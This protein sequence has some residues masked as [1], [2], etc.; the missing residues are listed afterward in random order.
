[1]TSIIRY[2][3]LAT[4]GLAFLF[5]SCK[6]DLLDLDKLSSHIEIN[7]HYVIP[8]LKANITLGDI[9]KASDTIQHHAEADGDKLI[10]LVFLFDS[11]KTLTATDYLNELPEIDSCVRSE[12]L[13]LV[14]HDGYFDD[15]FSETVSFDDLLSDYYFPAVKDRYT[16]Y[17]GA[18]LP[19]VLQQIHRDTCAT[20]FGLPF[21][22][23][24]SAKFATG[25]INAHITN[26]FDVPMSFDL[27]L[28]QRKD[29]VWE[30]LG[31]FPFSTEIAKKGGKAYN[32]IPARGV[33]MENIQSGNLGYYFENM[34]ISGISGGAMGMK[35]GLTIRFVLEQCKLSKGEIKLGSNQQFFGTDS[36]SF[37][38]VTVLKQKRVYEMLV[39]DGSLFYESSSTFPRDIKVMLTIPEATKNGKVLTDEFSAKANMRTERNLNLSGNTIDFTTNVDT[40]Y[41]KVKIGLKYH[42]NA[43]KTNE[44]IVFDSA[45]RIDLM[46]KN[47]ERLKFEWI[48]GNMELD[49]IQIDRG[50]VGFNI[51]DFLSNYFSG[52]ITINDPQFS[53]FIDNGCGID[54]MAQLSLNAQR[55]GG[56]ERSLFLNGNTHD[57]DIDAPTFSENISVKR[58][59]IDFN[60]SNSNIVNLLSILPD[61][62]LYSGVVYTNYAHA[63][64]PDK[65]FNHL[66][67][68][69]NTNI[70]AELIIPLHMSIKDL[71]LRKHYAASFREDL[72]GDGFEIELLEELSLYFNVKNQFPL[73]LKIVYTL[74]D[75]LPLNDILLDTLHVSLIRAQSPNATGKVERHRVNEYTDSLNIT[76]SLLDNFLDA[77]M[78]RTDIILNTA[79]QGQSAKFYSHYNLQIA[80]M[81][82]AKAKV[83][84]N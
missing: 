79:E 36:I 27:I 41:N 18:A 64:N 65:I 16:N 22:S 31:T 84:K 57:F 45:N 63:A 19:S 9:L 37:F 74:W 35:N 11:L 39:R 72:I 47:A 34:K 2:I 77:N 68:D 80:I 61:Q 82:G 4:F 44:F 23:I 3:T 71:S 70:G 13:G 40:P 60:K 75:T 24:R 20:V 30:K 28:A 17:T 7:P 32:S 6:R 59:N 12:T 51:S 26:D 78:I 69:A 10:R 50:Q 15:A 62:L 14:P 53:L 49:T 25:T 73:D 56:T 58:T 83:V 66:H 38:E 81:A 76:G 5:V 8:L 52:Q 46:F 48:K 55:S 54:G 67:W 33:Y 42:L 21:K 29:G 43:Y 1:M